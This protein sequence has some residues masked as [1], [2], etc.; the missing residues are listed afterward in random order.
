MCSTASDS[1]EQPGGYYLIALAGSRRSRLPGDGM[2][3]EPMTRA[4]DYYFTSISPWAYIGHRTFVDLAKRHGLTIAYKPVALVETV[5]PET[6]GLPLAKRHPS[7]VRY[8][9]L[10]L[11][12][13]REKRGLSFPLKPKFWPFE[14]V[15]VDCIIVALAARGE[16]VEAF[17]PGAFAAI[18]EQE[19]DLRDPDVVSGLLA[20]GGLDAKAVMKA[21]VDAETKRAYDDNTRGAM[22][23][24][25]F[26]S[27]SYVL[28]GE[29]FWGQDRLDLLEDA[30]KSGRKP[31]APCR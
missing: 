16:D 26:G 28:D 30:L 2:R 8:R 27:P 11:Q 14:P 17:L 1:K 4:I 25:V 31:F 10:E 3:Q 24:G 20:R 15:F 23:A 19:K 22:E 9:D 18:F 6:G 13:W 21:A 12:R 5:Y 29:I 7:R